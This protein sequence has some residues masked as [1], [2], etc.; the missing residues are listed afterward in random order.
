LEDHRGI[1]DLEDLAVIDCRRYAQHLRERVH[2]EDDALSAASAHANGPYFTIVRAFLGW[3]V[4]D[5]RIDANP[6]R[7]NRVKEALPEH[8]GD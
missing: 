6:A 5:E 3:C 1:T 2:D 4:D 8:H 7:P